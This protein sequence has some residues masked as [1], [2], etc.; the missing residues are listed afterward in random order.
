MRTHRIMTDMLAELGASSKLNA[1]RGFVEMLWTE[2]RRAAA[3]F[4]DQHGQD[5]GK[6]SSTD[7]DALLEEC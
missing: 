1:E 7:L 6:R 3:E 4:L 5:L 2:G